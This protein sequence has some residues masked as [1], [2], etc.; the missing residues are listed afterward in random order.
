MKKTLLILG[1]LCCAVTSS[2]AQVVGTDIGDIAPEI[3]LPDTKGNNIVL[4]SLRGELVLVDFWASWCGPC[5]KEQPELI[6]LY[7][8]YSGKFS[9]YSVSMDTKK[10]LWTGAIAKQKLPWTQVSDLKYWNSPVI[11]DYM[12]QSVPLNFLIDK[13]GI[14]LAK[15]IHGN[16]LNEMLKS[17]L[18]AQ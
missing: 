1:F 18:T 4:S 5:I 7:N 13:N 6:K 10:A 8:T 15:N 11:G 14:I 9:I 12:L 17:L 2:K 3:D 16:A